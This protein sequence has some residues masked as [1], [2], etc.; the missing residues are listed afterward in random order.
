VLADHAFRKASGYVP[1]PATGYTDVA[2]Q[3]LNIIDALGLKIPGFVTVVEPNGGGVAHVPRDQWDVWQGELYQA[4][5]R[6]IRRREMER[7][8][9]LTEEEIAR[10]AGTR[11]EDDA[12]LR[13]NVSEW[14]ERLRAGA[15]TWEEEDE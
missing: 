6:R 1:D 4:N 13:E 12:V 10:L 5:L 8:E 7:G 11:I 15:E 14:I 2:A 3:T 9:V